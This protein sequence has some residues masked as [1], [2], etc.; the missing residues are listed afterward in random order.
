[1]K[2]IEEIF[3]SNPSL[4]ETKEVKELVDQFKIQF[5]AI[6]ETQSSFWNQ[7]TSLTMNSECFVIN[8]IPCEEVI[9]Q[10]NDLAFTEYCRKTR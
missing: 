2:T 3:A 6:K 10:I 1:M 7:V 4:L 9:Q 8:G 5:K